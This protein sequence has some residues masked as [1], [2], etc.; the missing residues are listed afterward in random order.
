MATGACAPAHAACHAKGEVW[1]QVG[2]WP[3]R[4]QGNLHLFM[5][6]STGK[7]FTEQRGA[8]Q[9][10]SLLYIEIACLI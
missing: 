4:L 10:T 9:E 5:K 8:M 3:K 6:A 2:T 1:Q 7:V